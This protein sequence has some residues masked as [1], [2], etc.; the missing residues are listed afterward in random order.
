MSIREEVLEVLNDFNPDVDF[1]NETSLVTDK[2]L[3][4]MDLVY[5][6]SELSDAFDIQITA[7]DFVEE[8]F[9]SVDALA[10]MVER[11]QED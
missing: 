7:A 10:A 3:D 2:V 4:S 11:L 8:N 9:N 5:L 1:E 6:V